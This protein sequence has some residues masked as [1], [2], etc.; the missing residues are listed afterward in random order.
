MELSTSLAGDLL[1]RSD[2]G[3]Q[4]TP[5]TSSLPDLSPLNTYPIG[6]L[7]G[8]IDSPIIAYSEQEEIYY[9]HNPSAGIGTRVSDKIRITDTDTVSGSTLSY[10]SSI[11]KQDPYRS[12]RYEWFR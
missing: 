4:L 7:A 6:T 10:Y 8:F 3:T 12:K 9:M 2:L 5:Y 1:Y 11:T